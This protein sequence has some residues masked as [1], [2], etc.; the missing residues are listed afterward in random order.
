MLVTADKDDLAQQSSIEGLAYA[1][2]RPS[3][4]ERL[5]SDP[6]FLKNL[7][8]ALKD[9]HAKSPT[10]YGGLN[11]LHNLTMSVPKLSEDQKRMA[12]LQAY[13]NASKP[14]MERDPL[15]DDQHVAS[16]RKAVFDAGA[17]PV[18][19]T[20]SQNCSVA[21]IRLI[22]AIIFSIS[23]NKSLRGRMIQQGAIK[24]VL[25]AYSAFPQEEIKSRRI[26][27]HALARLLISTDPE[28]AFGNSPPPINSAIKPLVSLLSDDPTS[29]QRDL[30][31]TFEA[32]LALT[33]LASTNDSVRNPII[34]EVFPTIDEFFF[35][36]N[37]LIVRATAE[38]ICNLVQSDKGVA[39]FADGKA[40]SHA[41]MR[42]L[43]ALADC[44]D[45]AARRAVAGA[46]ATMTQWDAATNWIIDKEVGGFANLL[47]FLVEDYEDI[48]Y[49]GI[50]IILNLL[51]HSEKYGDWGINKLKKDGAYE[52]VKKG[53]MKAESKDVVALYNEV[54]KKLMD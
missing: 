46:F 21:S 2:L 36:R 9:N 10:T 34:R 41:R 26:A 29:E 7:I 4:K 33:N 32:L 14:F 5:A 16:R 12:Q 22:V 3:V 15:D 24:L 52:V 39:A 38:L 13:A 42:L 43:M 18:L 27:A 53:L 44:E 17:V 49:R 23:E 35:Q 30:L 37:M 28:L 19:V 45:M 25:W 40:A 50:V 8:N 54:L 11:I 31:Q 6:T 48:R 47:A 1:S 20:Q 51:N